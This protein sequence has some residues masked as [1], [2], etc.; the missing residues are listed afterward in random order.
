MEPPDETPDASEGTRDDLRFRLGQ[1]VRR[2]DPA[3]FDEL[4]LAVVRYQAGALPAY[5]R[6]VA[7]Q[8]RALDDW[9]DAPLVPTELFSELDLCSVPA[10]PRRKDRLFKTS[11]TTGG[12]AR[13]GKRRVPD[14][15]LYDQAMAAPFIANVLGGD[16]TPRLWV[17]L[18]PRAGAAPESSL[19]YMVEGLATALSSE[20]RWCFDREGLDAQRARVA[21]SEGDRPVLIVATAF[22]MLDL[23]EALETS[24]RTPKLPP[25]SRIMLTGGFKGRT[26]TLDEDELLL[27]M[28][29]Q[30]GV[31]KDRVVPE[32]GMTELTS[33]AYGRPLTPMASLR[34][35]IIDPTSGAELPAGSQGLVACFDLLNLDN[36]SAILTSDLGVLDE[37]GGL[38]LH[39]RLSGAM[40]RGC[41][42]TTEEL[43]PHL[44]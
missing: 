19:S 37:A 26:Q 23:L 20:T 35:R 30:L 15:S 27:R 12:E 16:R 38:T 10:D 31:T 2:P 17:S 44:G 9:R 36:V 1:F 11:G 7:A 22:A 4:A 13:R 24:P 3:I 32:Y 34:F 40:P 18:V 29:R 28:R 43:R 41:S 5:G 39:G 8:G 25:G 14:L 6:L 21:L 42:L 33:Q